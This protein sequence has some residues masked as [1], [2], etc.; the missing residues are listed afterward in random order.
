MAT[1]HQHSGN[2]GRSDPNVGIHKGALVGEDPTRRRPHLVAV[3]PGLREKKRDI[4]HSG[5]DD[6]PLVGAK[7]GPA[8]LGDQTLERLGCSG[9]EKS[10]WPKEEMQG[11]P[12]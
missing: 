1:I 11:K 3:G 12:G 4:P 9:K 10:G 8:G 2:V 6:S 7:Y 5:D